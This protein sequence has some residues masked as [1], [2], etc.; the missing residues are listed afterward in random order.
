MRLSSLR[1]LLAAV[2]VLLPLV[3]LYQWQMPQAKSG[4]PVASPSQPAGA[5]SGQAEVLRAGEAAWQSVTK[6][7]LYVG[8][9]VRAVGDLRLSFSE[10]TVVDMD[11]GAQIAIASMQPQD[12]SLLLVHKA[13]A[14]VVDTNNPRFRLE[15]QAMALTVERAKFRVQ[16]DESGNASV[17]SQRGLVYSAS[18]GDTVA[19]AEGE[20]LRT[21]I[22]QRATVVPGTPIALPPPPPPPPRTPTATATPVPPTQPPERIHIVARGDTLSEIAAKYGVSQ[23]AIAKANGMDNPNMLYI[24]QKLIIPPA[25]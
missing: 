20:S 11:K 7:S 6:D 1:P 17:V 2:A 16:V 9:A 25:K 3:A 5:L 13:G 19:V 14:V 24:G 22:G 4:A 8:D 23:E 12:G 10:G 15:S 18:N 21:G